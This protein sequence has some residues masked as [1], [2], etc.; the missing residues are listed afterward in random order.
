MEDIYEDWYETA[1]PEARLRL[2]DA[3]TAIE[4]YYRFL[5]VADHRHEGEASGPAAPDVATKEGQS[6]E[7]QWSHRA[8]AAA[9]DDLSIDPEA[10]IGPGELAAVAAALNLAADIAEQVFEERP[11]PIELPRRPFAGNA[12]LK[13]MIALGQHTRRAGVENRHRFDS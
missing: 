10:E 4:S 11:N 2:T 6:G 7:S 13:K 3:P 1:G 5:V 9:L 8:V 12:K